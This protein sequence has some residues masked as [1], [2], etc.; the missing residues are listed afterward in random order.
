MIKGGGDA[1]SA[2]RA[3]LE[4]GE[5]DYAWNLQ[6]EPEILSAM[7]AAGKGKVIASYGTGV[8]R[9]MVNFTNP[10]PRLGRQA[11]QV[12]RG[13][14]VPAPLPDRPR[15][16]QGAVDGHRPQHASPASSTALPAEPTCNVLSG[17]TIYAST[18]NDACL[19]QDIDGRQRAAGRGRL[20][21]VAP[22]ASARRMASA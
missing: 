7:E 10:D 14:P 19:T 2:A 11:L 5:A 9:I 4:T 16:A 21:A 3:V 8:E 12:D 20:G 1:P 18:A 13:R 6:V 17:P 15:R 22:T